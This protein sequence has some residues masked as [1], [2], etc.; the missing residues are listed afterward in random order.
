MTLGELIK[1]HRDKHDLSQRQFAEICGLSNGY[2]SMIE[3]GENPKTKLPVTP[4]LPV[5]QKIATGMGIKVTSL[6]SSIDDMP[7]DIRD[8]LLPEMQDIPSGF[9]PVPPMKKVPIIGSIACGTPIT[10]EENIE[11]YADALEDQIVDFAL[12]CKGDSMIDAGIK[13]GDIVYIKKQPEVENGQLAAVRIENEATLKRVYRYSDTLILQPANVN[14]TP[15]SY[16][17]P[18]LENVVIE[19]LVVGFTHWMWKR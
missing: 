18:E 11:G 9:I 4:T 6:F 2:I 14:Y 16:T 3:K 19:G 5:Y 10:A 12:I 8:M 15:Q 1:K 13:D 7:V 17:G